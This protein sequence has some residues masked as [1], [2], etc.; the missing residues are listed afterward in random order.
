MR[1]FTFKHV[2][3]SVFD[4]GTQKDFLWV[5]PQTSGKG[6]FVTIGNRN[7]ITVVFIK[8]EQLPTGADFNALFNLSHPIELMSVIQYNVKLGGYLYSWATDSI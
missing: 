6:E 7:T 5:K 2:S 8:S 1:H 4:N 3:P